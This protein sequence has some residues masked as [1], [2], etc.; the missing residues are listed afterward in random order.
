MDTEKQLTCKHKEKPAKEIIV[1]KGR[2]AIIDVERCEKCG[3]ISASVEAVEKARK[4]LNPSF[5]EK[6]KEF[7]GFG[8]T[9]QT[10]ASIFK[11]K[12]L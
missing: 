9:E 2:T 11:G 4:E 6:L 5:I 8:K 7:L 10:E 1:Q 3:E 12:V